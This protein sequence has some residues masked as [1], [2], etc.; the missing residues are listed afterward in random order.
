MSSPA[1]STVL[2]PPIPLRDSELP[3]PVLLALL[4]L[5]PRVPVSA[6]PLVVAC[7]LDSVVLPLVWVARLR[8]VVSL[9]SLR[10]VSPVLLLR[11]LAV[12][13]VLQVVLVSHL[14]LLDC[15]HQMLTWVISS[16]IRSSSRF[17]SPGCSP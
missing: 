16:W 8:Q 10:A 17:P 3:V 9:D 4:Q 7:P 12:V 5:S 14:S 1:L 13:V 11:A 6:S 15:V 2:L